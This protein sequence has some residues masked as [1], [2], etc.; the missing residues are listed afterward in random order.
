MLIEIPKEIAEKLGTFPPLSLTEYE[1]LRAE[2]G[3]TVSGNLDGYDCP[4]CKNRGFTVRVDDQGNQTCV[5]CSCMARRRSIKRIERS[6]LS[7]SLN[8]CTFEKF[9]ANEPWREEMKRMALSFL[10][11]CHGKWFA[12]MGSIGAGKTHICTAICGEL[13]KAGKEVRYMRW[14]DDGGRLKAE[15]NDSEEFTRLITPFKTAQV[16]YIDDLFKTQKGKEVTTGDV[17]LAFEI[18]NYRY[19]IRSLV[20]VISS[21][22]TIEDILEIDEAVGSRIY[23]RCKEYYIRLIERGNWRLK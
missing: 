8:Q 1:K 3:N 19:G 22:K 16:L 13:L 6:G 7:D 12:A 10:N 11:D 2:W 23:E 15:I 14:K 20:T 18:L 21:E 4:V 9:Q 17:N 5:E